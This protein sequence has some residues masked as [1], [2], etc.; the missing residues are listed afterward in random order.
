MR[1]F[2]TG[3]ID[4]NGG[5]LLGRKG[6]QILRPQYADEFPLRAFILEEHDPIDDRE[7]RVV[8]GAA[9]ILAGLVA[10]PALTDE[11][12]TAGDHLPAKSLH[13]QP[14]AVRIASVCR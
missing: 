2:R 9:D 5:R 11:D 3:L 4:R 10:R 6:G 14:L 1:S 13:A 8:L 12:A 7:E